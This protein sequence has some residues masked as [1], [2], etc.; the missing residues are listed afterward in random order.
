VLKGKDVPGAKETLDPPKTLYPLSEEQLI[1][2]RVQG[3][4][5]IL[6]ELLAGQYALPADELIKRSEEYIE[7]LKKAVARNWVRLDVL[8]M[9]IDE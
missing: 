5:S 1:R 4:E 6:F 2:S 9:R 3:V 8:A 7:D